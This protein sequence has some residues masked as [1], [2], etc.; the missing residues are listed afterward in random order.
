MKLLFASDSFKGTLSSAD[1]IRILTKAA[2]EIFGDVEIMGVP[3]ADGGEGTTDAV[4]LARDGETVEVRVHDPLM[5]EITAYYGCFGKHQAILEMA[6]AS[7]LPLLKDQDRNPL[8]TTTYGTGELIRQALDDGYRKIAIAIGGSATNDG[9]MGAMRALGVKFLDKDGNELEGRGSDLIKVAHIDASGI[10]P[11]VAETEFRIMCDV[12]NPLC[13]ETGATYTFGKQ[14]GGTPEVLDQLE[15]GM[16]NYRDIIQTEFG[17]NCDLIHGSGA[18]GGL[19]AALLVFLKGQMNSGTKTVLKLIR[20]DDMLEG[21]DLVVTGEGQTDW[22]SACGKVMQG[23][24]EHGRAAGVPVI[25]ICGSLG[26]GYEQMYEHGIE[27]LIT[28]VDGPMNLDEALGNA[29]DLYYKAAIRAFRMVKT[30]MQINS[31]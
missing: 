11:A 16:C 6:S 5:K 28:T 7:G 17:I 30:G 14:K 23:V 9:G 1:T 3:V 25:G 4:V 26:R 10:H 20:F 18:A 15:K 22:Q 29:E 24:G 13:G 19:G 21:V 31:K 8:N 12:N 2:E 27:S